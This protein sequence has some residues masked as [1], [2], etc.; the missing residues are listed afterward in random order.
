KAQAKP[1]P[2]RGKQDI[3]ADSDITL[4][5]D[6]IRL[7]PDEVKLAPQTPSDSD[8]TGHS[9]SASGINLSTPADGGN[10][11]DAAPAGRSGIGAGDSGIAL[12]A[13][14]VA[15]RSGR[16]LATTEGPAKAGSDIFETDFEVPVLDSD[17]N[18][19]SAS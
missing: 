8:V 19:G 16:G 15:G 9:P 11:L 18:L 13:A 17:D 2:G 5:L 1:K 4:A 3:S 10:A 12:D 6:N 7:A 14:P